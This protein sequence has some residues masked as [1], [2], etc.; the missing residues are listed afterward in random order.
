MVNEINWRT[1][2]DSRTGELYQNAMEAK[3]QGVP[4]EDLVEIKG[5]L[6][7]IIRV[8]QSVKE[9]RRKKNK[10]ARKSRKKNRK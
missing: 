5:P 4:T 1:T 9:D 8:S 2:V 7:S 3:L 6:E 10:K